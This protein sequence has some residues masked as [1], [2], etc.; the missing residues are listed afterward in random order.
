MAKITTLTTENMP[1]EMM[2]VL[3]AL[4][5]DDNM[6]GQVVQVTVPVN[7]EFEIPHTL[8]VVP[9]YR[10]ILRMEGAAI[11][12][13]GDKEWTDKAIYLKAVGIPTGVSNPV[14]TSGAIFF[15]GDGEGYVNIPA[16]ISNLTYS[17][18][19]I[20]VTMIIMRN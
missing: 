7:E 1:S 9:K 19:E 14:T 8:K 16:N 20:T 2:S 5:F 17:E 15:P 10:I 4:S 11:L 6:S 12:V 3:K 13:N 18:S